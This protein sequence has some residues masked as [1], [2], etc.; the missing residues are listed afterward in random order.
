MLEISVRDKNYGPAAGAVVDASVFA[1]DGTKVGTYHATAGDD[2]VATIPVEPSGT[3]AF[4]V[5]AD[6]HEPGEKGARL[7]R[8]EGA[9]LVRGTSAEL[10]DP[11]PRPD[12]LEAIAKATGGSVHRLPASRLPDLSFVDPDVVE[13]GR[14]KNVD[15]WDRWTWLAL[16]AGSLAIEWSLRRR[17]GRL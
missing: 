8:E 17:W 9:F 12:L 7:G 15:L 2:G 10:V 14:K 4:K 6:A 13:V 11:A 3:G 1:A 5:V 16:L